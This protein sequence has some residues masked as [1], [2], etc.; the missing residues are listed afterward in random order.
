MGR[1]LTF[2]LHLEEMED[3]EEYDEP[4]RQGD[5]DVKKQ[6]LIGINRKYEGG[7]LGV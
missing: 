2:S 3:A 5:R 6:A 7:F 1:Y 4:P